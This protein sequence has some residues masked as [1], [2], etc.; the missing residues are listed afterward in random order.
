MNRTTLVLSVV[1]CFLALTG[2]QCASSMMNT[3]QLAAKNNDWEKAKASAS[4]EVALRP[5]NAQAWLILGRAEFNLG[6]YLAMKEAYD[7]A[8]THRNAETGAL[9]DADVAGIMLETSHAWS[10]LYDSAQ[11]RRGRGDVA[12]AIRTL[13]TAEVVVPGNPMTTYVL[14]VLHQQADDE[15]TAIEQFDRYI[16][17]TRSD[18]EKGRQEGLKLGFDRDRVIALLGNPSRPYNPNVNQ[19]G[20][21]WADRSL[22]VYYQGRA[23]ELT[24][25]GWDYLAAGDR[26]YLISGLSPDPYYSRAYILRESEEYD[27]ALELLEV[28]DGL[29]PDRQEDVGN[30]LGQIYIDAGRVDEAEAELNRRIAA[31]PENVSYR[32]RLSVLRSRQEDYA[33]AIDV[34]K[35]A[36]RLELE[37]GSEDHRNV[38]Y[39]LGVFNKNWGIKLENQAET[40][41]GNDGIE[42]ALEKYREAISYYRQL[43]EVQGTFDF[44]LLF[45]IGLMA[46]RI[47]QDDLLAGII[48]RYEQQVESP[49]YSENS[50]F[51][52]NLSTLYTYAEQ[53]EKAKAASARAKELGG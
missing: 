32:I 28:I 24:V 16:E 6:N 38:L 30:L 35:Q 10:L 27:R 12:G 37:E 5:D 23:P 2:F 36:L 19:L 50:R 51:W 40:S 8:L 52:R 21:Y 29:D 13:D 22:I 42:V 39:N 9:S 33:G 1:L 46:A 53:I 26:P 45:E 7:E 17:K 31:N 44:A 18:I 47:G 49:A 3:A 4:E 48:G 34:L 41:P 11:A 20:D 25:R 15:A 14:G 43:D